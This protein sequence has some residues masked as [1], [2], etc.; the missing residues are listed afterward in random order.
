M[1]LLLFKNVFYYCTILF[2]LLTLL[3]VD[4]E[5]NHAGYYIWQHWC[6]CLTALIFMSD[7]VGFLLDNVWCPTLIYSHI[8]FGRMPFNSC[9]CLN[10]QFEWYQI[11]QLFQ[12]QNFYN[13]KFLANTSHKPPPIWGSKSIFKILFFCSFD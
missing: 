5:E 10:L 9:F 6:S 13:L 4:L 3:T 8:Y 12:L 11:F 7:I 2:Q 1:L